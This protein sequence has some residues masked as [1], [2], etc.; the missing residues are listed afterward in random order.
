MVPK[1]KGIVDPDEILTA[2]V[3]ELYR[4]R[5]AMHEQLPRVQ[6]ATRALRAA[7]EDIEKDEASHLAASSM[8]ISEW[9]EQLKRIHDRDT[10]Q[11]W[12]LKSE[13]E[14]LLV[15]AYGVLS[16]ARAIRAA[17]T[18]ELNA[19]VQRA[20]STFEKAAPDADLL[21]HI[22]QHLDAYMRGEGRDRERLP[23]PT[24]G[25]AM[26][27]LP[28]GLA[29]YIGGKMFMLSEIQT[30]TEQLAAMIAEYTREAGP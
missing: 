4:Y 19:A 1:R 25:G 23:D 12:R 14:F 18:G 20:L 29:Y 10:P 5:L 21:R 17:S 13:A 6:A 26:A 3:G 9:T 27:M 24:K 11:F 8:D 16:M 22:H 7:R 2:C 30:A 28:D 15:A